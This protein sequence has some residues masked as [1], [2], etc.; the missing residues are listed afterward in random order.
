MTKHESRWT[1]ASALTTIDRHEKSPEAIGSRYISDFSL[2]V[3]NPE[4]CSTNL[5]WLKAIQNHG[6]FTIYQLVI[7]PDKSPAK[8]TLHDFQGWCQ[9]QGRAHGDPLHPGLA[10]CQRSP[11]STGTG[12]SSC[13]CGDARVVHQAWEMLVVIDGEWWWWWLLLIKTIITII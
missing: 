11:L 1:P 5:G 6:M 8:S 3:R 4:S 10:G 9:V 12:D 2:W 13:C 7:R